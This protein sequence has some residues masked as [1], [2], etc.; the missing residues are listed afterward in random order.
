MG[1]FSRIQQ[2]DQLAKDKLALDTYNK[3]STAERQAAFK[4]QQAL[5]GNLKGAVA[6]IEGY[7]RPYDIAL[8]KNVY[9]VVDL[10]V[11]G[12][13]VANKTQSVADVI[14]KLGTLVGTRAIKTAPAT[15]G[16]I[17]VET[18]GIRGFSPCR[19]TLIKKEGAP[20]DVTSRFTGNTY[21]YVK[22]D[23][24]SSPIGQITGE[25]SEAAALNTIK[26]I[27]TAAEKQTWSVSMT[28]Q[29]GV[30]VTVV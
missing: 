2:G 4:A 20:K 26:N 11:D 3:K 24:V 8:T 17:L 19:I 1:R 22:K 5:T 30:T 23:A 6:S 27:L 12:T 9:L 13:V 16:D 15:A 29:K 7:I 18:R 10:P 28:R 25:A 14:T 21:S